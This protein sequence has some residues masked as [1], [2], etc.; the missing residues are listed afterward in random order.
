MK[1]LYLL[2]AGFFA[3]FSSF[4]KS[5]AG[6]ISIDGADFEFADYSA[7]TGGESFSSST[8]SDSLVQMKI[9]RGPS[10]VWSTGGGYTG[11]GTEINYAQGSGAASTVEGALANG[12]YIS[13]VLETE[14]ISDEYLQI[15]SIEVDLRRNGNGAA[16]NYQ[17]AY[18][19]DDNWTTADLIGAPVS[20]LSTDTFTLSYASADPAIS[21]AAMNPELRLYY[22]D[23]NGSVGSNGNTHITR[24]T[25]T[26][27][28]TEAPEPGP[29]PDP[30]P[31]P[32]PIDGPMNIV[33]IVVDDMGF[34][35]V[36]CYGSEIQTPHIDSLAAQGLRFTS[37]Y[38]CAR[39]FGKRK[40]ASSCLVI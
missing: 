7:L 37:F 2:C 8:K 31:D 20:D 39:P 4:G 6:I 28:T 1:I 13:V 30:D 21:E 23:N 27:S 33:L 9:E 22:W 34:S 36:G 38:N 5:Q 11:A 29:D 17:W 24:V 16:N 26:Y 10:P 3:M 35:D 15:D 19:A 12:A 25:A 32:E 14:G 18:S 40:A